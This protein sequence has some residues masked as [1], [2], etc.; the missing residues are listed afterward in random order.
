MHEAHIL[1]VALDITGRQVILLKPLRAGSGR[2]LPIWIGEQ[3]AAAILIAVEGITVPRPLAHDLMRSMLDALQAR[4]DRVEITRIEEGTFYAVVTVHAAGRTHALDARPS[5]AIALARRVGA[6]IW[7][8]D[9]VLERA[10]VPDTFSGREPDLASP[11]STAEQ[12]AR[13]EE[14]REFLAEVDPEDFGEG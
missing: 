8:A 1:G 11:L 12:E 9:E 2:I 6:S 13:L 7:I 3:E 5:D 10:G 14:F 4:V